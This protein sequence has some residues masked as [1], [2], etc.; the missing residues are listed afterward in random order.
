MIYTENEIIKRKSHTQ[1]NTLVRISISF[2]I[3]NVDSEN[4]ECV[5]DKDIVD[6][7][8]IELE[9]DRIPNRNV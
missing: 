4:C 5:T 7:S 6:R 9:L 8:A 3:N 2:S 1:N